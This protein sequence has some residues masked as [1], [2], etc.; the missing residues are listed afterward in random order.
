MSLVGGAL[1]SGL[2]GGTL[3]LISAHQL[4]SVG[5]RLLSSSEQW[6]SFITQLLLLVV[7]VQDA[8]ARCLFG[9]TN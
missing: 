6:L 9:D 7:E 5:V 2:R 3:V 4:L 8:V 1:D